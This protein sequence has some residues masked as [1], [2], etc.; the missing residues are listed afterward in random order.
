[1]NPLE[2]LELKPG[3]TEKDAKSNFRRLSLLHHPDKPSGNQEQFQKIINAYQ[4]ICDHP[5]CLGQQKEAQFPFA[6][7][8]IPVTVEDIYFGRKK[9]IAIEKSILCNACKGTGS[10]NGNEGLCPTCRG[11]GV[12]VSRALTLM[13]RK[14]GERCPA[15]FGSG[16]KQGS[17]CEECQGKK[18]TQIKTNISFELRPEHYHKKYALL[19]GQGDVLPDGTKTDLCIKLDI[20][21]NLMYSFEGKMLC[22][23]L[24]I[25]PAQRFAGD[26]CWIDIFGKTF[27]CQVP[28]PQ[29]EII[30]KDIR[31]K[32]KIER[33]ILLRIKTTQPI[34]NE[35]IRNLY[36]QII[37]EEKRLLNNKQPQSI[38]NPLSIE[39]YL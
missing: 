22:R 5:E 2:I 27:Q 26:I 13:G 6:Y 10:K 17:A 35:K 14:S 36:T 32:Y 9:N 33:Q 18:I 15:C 31:S 20:Q 3:A 7:V 23:D 11:N 8:R 24:F 30:I 19:R 1:M 28:S 39:D 21:E 12:I 37:K 4:Y 25:T 16:L 38:E 34:L 29:D